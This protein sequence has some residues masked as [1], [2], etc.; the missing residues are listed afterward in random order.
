MYQQLGLAAG[1]TEQ[2]ALHYSCGDDSRV[3]KNRR[4]FG[5]CY[6]QLLSAPLGLGD[7]PPSWVQPVPLPTSE[8]RALLQWR[9]WHAQVPGYLVRLW[10]DPA[11]EREQRV[12]Y[13]RAD[14][15]LEQAVDGYLAMIRAG[16]IVPL[17]AP[18]GG[19]M[20]PRDVLIERLR[21]AYTACQQQSLQGPLRRRHR[22]RQ[23][24]VAEAMD[25]PYGTLRRWRTDL[26]VPYPPPLPP[27]SSP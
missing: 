16:G 9:A 4:A 1:H 21:A 25:V 10:Y 12:R 13:G 6:V 26:D 24:D 14:P 27:P 23:E 17:G 11:T 20:P 8:P 15:S 5:G 7:R 2:L 3:P 18:T 19:E 22:P